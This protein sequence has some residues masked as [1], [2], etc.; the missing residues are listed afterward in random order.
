MPFRKNIAKHVNTVKVLKPKSIAP[1]HGPIWTKPEKIIENY[2]LWTSDYVKPLVV[3]PY[4]SMHDSIKVAV[5]HFKNKL[6]ELGIQVSCRNISKTPESLLVQ[7]GELIYDL[8]DAA[9]IVFAF[10]TVLGG[11]HPAIIYS[12]TTVNAMQPKTPISGMIC[13]FGWASKATEYIANITTS[14]KGNRLEPLIFKGK[15]MKNDIIEIE[16]YAEEIAKL[17]KE[18]K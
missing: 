9:A 14:I 11:P 3:I 2:E 5:E 4:V 17:I 13:S 12:A 16:K 8:V 18:L 15:P 6:E 7:T 10:S 1:S